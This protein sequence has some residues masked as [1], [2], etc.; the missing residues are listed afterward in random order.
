VA[1]DFG[2]RNLACKL[3][4]EHDHTCDPEEK[5]IPAY[6]AKLVIVSSLSIPV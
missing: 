1:V 5:D 6:E 3:E 2:E 4:T